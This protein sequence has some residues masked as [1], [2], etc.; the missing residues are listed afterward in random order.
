M[1]PFGRGRS[2]VAVTKLLNLHVPLW[3]VRSL[4][5]IP[6]T[7]HADAGGKVELEPLKSDAPSPRN[8]IQ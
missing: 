2:V 4:T 3:R 1:M 5:S 6:N 8:G 7:R